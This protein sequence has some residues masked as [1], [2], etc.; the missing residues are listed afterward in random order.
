MVTPNQKEIINLAVNYACPQ[1]IDLVKNVYRE[2]YD[3][4]ARLFKAKAES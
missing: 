4:M 1:A 2:W 3:L